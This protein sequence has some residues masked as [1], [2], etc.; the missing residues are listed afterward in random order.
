MTE[1][2]L[3]R[4]TLGAVVPTQQYG[5]LQPQIEVTGST[6]EEMVDLGLSR[7]KMIWDRAG[8]K[9]L[10][11]DR[12]SSEVPQGEILRC[13]VSGTEV[14]FDPIAHTYHDRQGRKYLGGSTFASRYKKP[15]EGELIAGKMATKHGVEAGEILDMW[16]LNAEAS[17]TFG[18]AVHAALQLYGEYLELSKS[19]KDGSDESALTSNPVLRPIVEAF[20]TDERK[21]EKAYYEEFV[22]DARTLR[23]GLIDRLVVE[24]GGTL[25]VEDYKTN[26]SVEK[27]ETVLEPFKN[28]VP[29]SALGI[30]FIQLSY[31]AAIL[32]AH[33]RVVRAI[34]VHHWRGDDGWVTHEHEPLNLDA[35]FT[36][37]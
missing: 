25:V 9:P 37:Q 27:P 5:N 16:K 10:E 31:Y 21:A 2:P 19:V 24:D 3:H 8:E 15:F 30:Y 17:S 23:C 14:I 13:R 36:A 4:M 1:T 35:A 7:M 22:A 26:A 20:F 32:A 12:R 33:G 34:R 29:N 18:T 28:V 6:F 11:I